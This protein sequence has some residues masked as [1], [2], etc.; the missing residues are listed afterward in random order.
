MKEFIANLKL[1]WRFAKY[2]KKNII[3]TTIWKIIM[4]IISVVVPLISAKIIVNLT[5]NK[6][7]QCLMF[8]V[9]MFV[10]ENLRNF[11]IYFSNYF[12]QV[13]FRET[14]VLMQKSLGDA[15]LKLETK[16]IDDN[17]SGVFI[18][19]LTNDV[20]LLSDEFSSINNYFGNIIT[21]I[22]IFVAIFVIN[23]WIFLYSVL[24]TILLYYIFKK[25]NS[26]YMYSYQV[27]D[28]KLV[29]NRLNEFQ[30]EDSVEVLYEELKYKRERGMKDVS[31]IKNI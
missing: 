3:K 19:R 23:K 6:I 18:Q 29:E 4:M 24:Y 21:N 7:Y 22:G 12:S 28:N 13:V 14:M 26:L 16:I 10:M 9:L 2:Q 8:V 15:M 25:R 11:A 27:E 31:R 20:S 1:V 5:D 30:E 17:G